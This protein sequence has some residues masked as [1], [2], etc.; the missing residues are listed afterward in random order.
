M[1]R[2]GIEP[3]TPDLRVRCPTDC[4]TRP[5][6]FVRLQMGLFYQDRVLQTRKTYQI[7]CLCRNSMFGPLLL[8]QTEFRYETSQISLA[9]QNNVIK[10]EYSFWRLSYKVICLCQ[11]SVF[12]PQLHNMEFSHETSEMGISVANKENIAFIFTIGSFIAL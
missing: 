4:A 9:Y 10:K 5:G 2:P 3:R 6:N 11:I 1:A 7:C 12:K 8:N